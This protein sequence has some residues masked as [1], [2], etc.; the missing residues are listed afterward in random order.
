MGVAI[1]DV[2]GSGV[3]LLPAA[4]AALIGGA[5]MWAILAAGLAVSLLVLCFAEAASHFDQPGSGYLYTREAFGPFVAFEVGWMTF[6]TRVTT[7]ASLSSRER[8]SVLPSNR[9]PSA[10]ARRA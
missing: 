2:V 1:N 9:S 5:S 10:C 7:S 6:L 3:Y 8:P 4:T